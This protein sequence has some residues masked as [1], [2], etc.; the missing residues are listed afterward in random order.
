[1]LTVILFLFIQ[2]A[3]FF[4]ILRQDN[5]CNDGDQDGHEAFNEEED[6]PRFEV[7]VNEGNAVSDDTIEETAGKS[8][9][10][11]DIL[12]PSDVPHRSHGKPE[13]YSSSKIPLGVHSR[14]VKGD[15][16]DEPSLLVISSTSI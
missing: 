11:L 14:Q 8:A 10:K 16:G 4:D 1:V 6:S 3:S 13:S 9:K 12:R 15:K 5:Q 2:P 7:R